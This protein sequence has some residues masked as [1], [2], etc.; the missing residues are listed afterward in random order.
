MSKT[1]HGE[2]PYRWMILAMMSFGFFLVNFATFQLAGAAGRLFP[3]LHPTP[4]EFGMC[5]FAPFLLTFVLGIPTGMITDR[6]G[7]RL[8]GNVF[9]I[10]SCAGIMGRAY[11]T[12][13]F[14]SLFGWMLVF[15]F[16]PVYFNTIGPKILGTWFKH[17]HMPIAMGTFIGFAGFGIGIGEG[18]VNLFPTLTGAFTCAWALFVI[19]TIWFLVGFRDKPKGEPE[20]PPQ[21]VLKYFG[22][23]AR[24]KFVW[25]DGVAVLFFFSAWV[26]TAGNLPHVP[27]HAKKIGDVAAGLLGLPLG[28]GGALG[29][30]FTPM[31]LHR[32]PKVEEWLALF[33]IMGAAMVLGSVLVPF[34]TTTWILVSVGA[35]I[36][37]GMLPLT[38]PYPI[39]LA[40]IGTPYGGS[41][42]GIISLLQMAGGF[43]IPSFAIAMI[44]EGDPMKTFGLLFALFLLCALFI[45]MLPERGFHHAGVE[46]EIL[47]KTM[48]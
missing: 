15:S 39:M 4:V 2:S 14:V 9:L 35:F 28:F 40:E 47:Q 8:V 31:I 12:T 41:A 43:F 5:L 48:A 36:A 21:P 38:M 37:N 29:G 45:L 22:A 33:V 18:T 24:N 19:T 7:S 17:E 20:M 1:G 32:L 11:A 6:L 10:I 25:I 16:A 46:Q 23:A 3:M 44:A 34:G 42:G 27:A 30:F 13:N 26:G